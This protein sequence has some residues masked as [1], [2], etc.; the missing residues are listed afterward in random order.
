MKLPYVYAFGI[1]IS[2]L[3]VVVDENFIE[4]IKHTDV[5][6]RLSLEGCE[7]TLRIGSMAVAA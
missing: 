5:Y 6:R 2:G 7:I 4:E 3:L 1:N